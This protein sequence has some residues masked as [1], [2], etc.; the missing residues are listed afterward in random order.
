MLLTPEGGAQVQ[1]QRDAGDAGNVL[2]LQPGAGHTICL[3]KP[4]ATHYALY[5]LFFVYV[6]FNNTV[7]SSHHQ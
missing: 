4:H 5:S 1:V 6:T 7:I 2:I 3:Y